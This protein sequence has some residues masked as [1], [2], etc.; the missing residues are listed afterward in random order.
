M[1]FK[2]RN[3]GIL[4]DGSKAHLYEVSNGKLSFC[5]SDYGCALISLFVPALENSQEVKKDIVLGLTDLSSYSR[6]WGSFG[7]IIGRFSNRINGASFTLD[8]KKY[9]LTENIDGSCLHGGFPRWEN[10]IWKAR[11]IKSGEGKGIRFSKTFPEGY[12][13]FPGKLKVT[14]EYILKETTLSFI[15]KAVSDKRTPV[16]ITNHTYFN[17][18]GDFSDIRNEKLR[19]NCSK[20]LSS[21]EKHNVN[22]R[23]LEVKGTP[24]DFT[25]LRTIG[26]NFPENGYDTS[27][28]TEAFRD[29]GGAAQTAEGKTPMSGKCEQAGKAGIN[30]S[31][32]PSRETPLVE[33]GTLIDE[34]TKIRM[35]V[36]TNLECVQLYTA[37][38][39]KGVFGKK[40][41]VYKPFSAVCLETQNFP[42]SPNQPNFP[43]CI[44]EP[45]KE[46]YE[47][48]DFTFSLQ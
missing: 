48:T 45:G 30:S 17:L 4:S 7:S 32:L 22:G 37:N 3:F 21:D 44:L 12:Q 19:L 38:Y 14:A 40:G 47:R 8:G 1:K 10:E 41:A 26:E 2:K 23:F 24:F 18:T 6:T 36:K 33:L 27:F 46:L 31:A 28:V 16:S 9:P 25:E 29:S 35:D 43:S 5:A 39:V 13:G 20:Y 15:F 34:K 42:D 11:F